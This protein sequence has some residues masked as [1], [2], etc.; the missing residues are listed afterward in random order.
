MVKPRQ[1]PPLQCSIALKDNPRERLHFE[2]FP[3]D[4]DESYSP[5]WRVRGGLA[6]AVTTAYW[7]KGAYGGFSLSLKY[8][9]GLYAR[10]NKKLEVAQSDQ[11]KLAHLD[12]ELQAMEAKAR[13]IEALCFPKPKKPRT[14]TERGGGIMRGQPPRILI[15]YGRFLTID[16]VVDSW[17][18]TWKPPFHP[19]SARP[20]SCIVDIGIQRMDTFYPD[21][22]DIRNIAS[23]RTPPTFNIKKHIRTQLKKNWVGKFLKQ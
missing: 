16:G 14:A 8:V 1:G 23:R 11:E 12:K 10:E 2:S 9:A 20:Y 3:A 19:V 22:Y 17:N 15:T 18:V 6:T 13:W 4:I 7:M 5:Q 21:Y